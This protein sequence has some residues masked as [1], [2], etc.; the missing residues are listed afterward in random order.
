M[1]QI[2][3]LSAVIKDVDHEAGI[4]DLCPE[5]SRSLSRNRSHR[6]SARGVHIFLWSEHLWACYIGIF[7]PSIP[8]IFTPRTVFLS[9][10]IVPRCPAS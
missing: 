2:R 10:V 6:S 8:P 7:F 5:V 1:M 9:L 4:D 3:N